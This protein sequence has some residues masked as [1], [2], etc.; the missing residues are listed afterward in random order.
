MLDKK[1]LA[2]SYCVYIY[3]NANELIGF[4]HVM[5]QITLAIELKKLGVSITFIFSSMADMLLE[6]L[7]KLGFEC[8]EVAPM[9]VLNIPSRGSLLIIDDYDVSSLKLSKECPCIYP[10]ICMDDNVE[11]IDYLFDAVIAPSDVL[12]PILMAKQVFQGIEFRFIRDEIKTT[13]TSSK[14]SNRVKGVSVTIMLGA[15][16]VQGL[17]LKV[18][19]AISTD[20]RIARVNVV[21][22]LRLSKD[23]EE[24]ITA[25]QHIE[26]RYYQSPKK[27]GNI[28]SNSD[29]AICGAGG[30][31]YEFLYLGIPTIAV[32]VADNQKQAHSSDLNSKAYFCVDASKDI[33]AAVALIKQRLD[34]LI[35]SPF[36]RELMAK[37]AAKSVTGEGAKL[38][39]MEVVRLLV[40][41]RAKD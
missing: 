17:Q 38:I 21:S 41:K 23:I 34:K 14:C 30:T 29:I 33:T 4:G 15:T 24:V 3:A 1:P 28:M 2:N 39:A 27:L 11:Q 5:R 19:N 25:N 20:R 40:E 8:Q 18:I 22:T 31:L 13:K 10:I 36:R 35:T 7:G 12:K 9:S 26:I 16:D 6:R 32:T 37:Y